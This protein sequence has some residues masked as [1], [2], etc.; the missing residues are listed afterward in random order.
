M[1]CGTRIKMHIAKYLSKHGIVDNIV[2]HYNVK[3]AYDIFN[4]HVLRR[5]KGYKNRFNQDEHK[6][7]PISMYLLWLH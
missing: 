1:F 7:K 3:L 2:K 5:M 4:K 6:I